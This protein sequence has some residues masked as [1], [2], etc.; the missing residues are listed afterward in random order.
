MG[1]IN[2]LI[3][4]LDDDPLEYLQD[5]EE[6]LDEWLMKLDKANPYR[7]LQTSYVSRL[8]T[9]LLSHWSKDHS[10]IMKDFPF[11]NQMPFSLKNEL[12]ETLFGKFI[13]DFE[14]LF[15]G[16]E[17]ACVHEILVNLTPKK[18]AKNQE[19]IKKDKP[20]D[21][22]YLL[23]KGNVNIYILYAVKRIL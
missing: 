10:C 13:K 22:L 2:V 8:K 14:V 3:E 18:F 1:N 17:A 9:H 12:I 16:L 6:K 19:I 23:L 21:A 11:F 4:K 7:K 5:E 15:K 20:A